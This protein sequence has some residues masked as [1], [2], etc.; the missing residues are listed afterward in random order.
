M[1]NCLYRAHATRELSGQL[2]GELVNPYLVTKRTPRTMPEWIH[3]LADEWFLKTKGYGFRTRALF[4]S[5]NMA[6]AKSYLDAETSLVRIQPAT[7]YALCFSERCPDLFNHLMN[8]GQISNERVVQELESLAYEAYV[9]GGLEIAA[10]SGCE[11][12]LVSERFRFEVI[13]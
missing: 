13:N 6:Q 11:V 1:N 5:G 8:L 9:D 7:S 4:C 2:S 12:M 3:V 10:R